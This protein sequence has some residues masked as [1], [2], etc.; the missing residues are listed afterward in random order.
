M[1]EKDKDKIEEV[2]E[3][4]EETKEEE[5][6]EEKPE[7]D[8][9]GKT[10]TQD[11]VNK[12]MTREKRQGAAS[13]YKELGIKAS[14]K[15]MLKAVKEFIAS[16]KTDTQKA[17]EHENEVNEANRRVIIAETKAEAM[18]TGVQAQYVDDVVTLVL[19]KM[20]SEEGLDV[21]TALGELKTKYPVWF[22]KENKEKDKEEDKTKKGQRGTGSSIKSGSK[23][24]DKEGTK[25]LGAR[26]AA[27]R[28]NKSS[29][30]S[31]WS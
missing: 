4:V 12:M 3:E 10:F 31:Y 9:K 19:A 11:E 27:N 1:A 29:K 16:K 18:Q 22:E 17:V 6:E 24:K 21:K 7:E 14:D 20:E 25:N 26:L 13:V 23:D 5:Q 8:S 28:R 15:D 2:E 30:K